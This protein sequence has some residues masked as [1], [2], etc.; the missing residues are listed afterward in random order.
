MFAAPTLA[1]MV[2]ASRQRSIGDVTPLP[3]NLHKLREEARI[4]TGI[5]DVYGSLYDEIGFG[6]VMN[7]C[8]KSRFVFK[9]IVKTRLA[10]HCSKL[11]DTL[12][13]EKKSPIPFSCS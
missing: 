13:A 8:S 3:V 4:V 2:I 1:E 11:M 6:R 12:D 10:R 7:Q 5:H 9:D